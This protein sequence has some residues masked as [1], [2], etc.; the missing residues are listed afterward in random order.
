[1]SYAISDEGV[2]EILDRYHNSGEI[3][4][5]VHKIMLSFIPRA[6]MVAMESYADR[7]DVSADIDPVRLRRIKTHALANNHGIVVEGGADYTKLEKGIKNK[8]NKLWDN[9]VDK[10]PTLNLL[11]VQAA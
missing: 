2:R 3:D 7:L 1:M 6:E 5:E 9:Q 11:L 4:D 10:D 8:S